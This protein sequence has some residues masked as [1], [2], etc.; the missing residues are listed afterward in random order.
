MEF[1]T[2]AM[3]KY[4][5]PYLTAKRPDK[6]FVTMKKEGWILHSRLERDVSYRMVLAIW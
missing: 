2:K 3:E 1:P 4:N 6:I 5:Q